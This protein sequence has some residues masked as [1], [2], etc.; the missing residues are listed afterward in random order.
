MIFN[1][2]FRT[3]FIILGD[4]GAILMFQ[5]LNLIFDIAR[6]VYEHLQLHF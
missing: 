3:K 5:F 2:L 6:V 1:V 4:R